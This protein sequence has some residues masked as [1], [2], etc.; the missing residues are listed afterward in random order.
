MLSNPE[1]SIF[2]GAWSM[3]LGNADRG[4]DGQFLEALLF[5]CEPFGGSGN[6]CVGSPQKRA[7]V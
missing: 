5:G 6:R 4:S 1:G 3:G 7:L 2:A